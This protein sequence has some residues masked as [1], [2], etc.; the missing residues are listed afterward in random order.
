MIFDKILLHEIESKRKRLGSLKKKGKGLVEPIIRALQSDALAHSGYLEDSNEPFHKIKSRL[1]KAQEAGKCLAATWGWALDNYSGQLDEPFLSEVGRRIDCD[2]GHLD[3]SGYRKEDVRLTGTNAVF[4]PRAEKVM[5]DMEALLNV[6]NDKSL[7]H[8]ERAIL[9][10]LHFARV[11]PLNDGN[12][13]TARLVQ[14]LILNEGGY[15]PGR[16]KRPERVMYQHVLREGMRGYKEREADSS[17]KEVWVEPFDISKQ[18]KNF[19][20]YMATKVNNTLYEALD[21]IINIPEFEVNLTSRDLNP[22]YVIGAKNRLQSTLFSNGTPGLVKV[23]N[24][25]EGR[26]IVYGD[27]PLGAIQSCLDKSKTYSGHF[28]IKKVT[29]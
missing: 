1:K 24:K 15:P 29:K 28:Q 6:V 2:G 9:F 13:R 18:E 26:I 14:N 8:L 25:K 11:H 10:H 22:G 12:G 7:G 23:P 27:V 3:F 20:G 16:I 17:F 19:F 21:E 4:P 5:R